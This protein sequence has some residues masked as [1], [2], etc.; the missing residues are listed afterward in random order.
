MHEWDSDFNSL[1]PKCAH[2]TLPP[3]EQRSKKSG[4]VAHNVL[5][6]VVLHDTLLQDIKKLN[7]F[8]H[9]GLPFLAV[10]ILPQAAVLQL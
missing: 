1:F 5:C 9:T 2:P 3:E 7:G 8:H 10:E 4:N 6:S